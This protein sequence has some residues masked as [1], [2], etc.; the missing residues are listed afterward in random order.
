MH[1]GSPC[2]SQAAEDLPSES[3]LSEEQMGTSALL[4]KQIKLTKKVGLVA[5]GRRGA[6]A[7]EASVGNLGS[8]KRQETCLNPENT[9]KP[10]YVMESE[11]EDRRGTQPP[12]IRDN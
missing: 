5:K 4:E 3:L 10:E 11:A 1:H 9:L 12:S 6:Q 8:L 2:T 7:E